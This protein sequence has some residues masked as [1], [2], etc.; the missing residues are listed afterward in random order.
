LFRAALPESFEGAPR[1]DRIG[2]S[3]VI[4]GP[5]GFRGGAEMVAAGHFIPV[6]VGRAIRRPVPLPVP[7]RSDLRVLRV[8]R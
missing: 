3:A 5:A 8:A 4:D 6:H 7:L 1:V 2:T